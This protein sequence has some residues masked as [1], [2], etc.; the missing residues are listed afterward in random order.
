MN[1]MGNKMNTTTYIKTE[2]SAFGKKSDGTWRKFMNSRSTAEVAK[3]DIVEHKK[4]LMY[5]P[6]DYDNYLE[7]AVR[8]RTIITTYE[9][10]Q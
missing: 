9:E 8:K 5:Y 2:Y 4:K 7:Y 6:H 1:D 10:W 3:N